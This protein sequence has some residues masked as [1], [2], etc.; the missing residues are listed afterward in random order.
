MGANQWHRGIGGAVGGTD[1]KFGKVVM[2]RATL[3]GGAIGGDIHG[4]SDSVAAMVD[5]MWG[6]T[7]MYCSTNID[8]YGGQYRISTYLIPVAR[9]ERCCTSR[10]LLSQRQSTAPALGYWTRG[11]LS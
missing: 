9:K 10:F 3:L 8:F 6:V 1:R 4:R 2:G 7:W 11:K 5:K